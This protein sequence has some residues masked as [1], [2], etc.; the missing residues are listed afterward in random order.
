MAVRI[1]TGPHGRRPANPNRRRGYVDTE[2]L[3][4]CASNLMHYGAAS[5]FYYQRGLAVP[6]KVKKL[7]YLAINKR[8]KAWTPVLKE[9]KAAS[10]RK[11]PVAEKHERRGPSPSQPWRRKRAGLSKISAYK[12]KIGKTGLWGRVQL[13][14]VIGRPPTGDDMLYRTA[15][16][17]W[18]PFYQGGQIA[19]YRWKAEPE[20][21]RREADRRKFKILSSL[22]RMEVEFL[23]KLME[24][25]I[26]PAY[27][28]GLK[29]IPVAQG[30]I[31]TR[32]GQISG[33]TIM[34]YS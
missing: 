15:Q 12:T 18:A 11:A 4:K 8:R 28:S 1:L 30:D 9:I 24:L 25:G 7:S 32:Q 21:V 26:T 29:E 5:G 2:E 16:Y 14:M 27:K 3:A 20:W 13:G 6:L 17:G 10:Q 23:R 34:R 22:G 19:H 33:Q 31:I